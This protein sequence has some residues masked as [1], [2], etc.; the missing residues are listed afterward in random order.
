V[1]LPDFHIEIAKQGWLTQ[2]GPDA[3]D[4]EAALRDL[5]SHGDIRLVIGGQTIATGSGGEFGISEAALGLLRT[6]TSARTRSPV[7]RPE[8]SGLSEEEAQKFQRLIPHGCGLFLMMNCNIGID[9][10]VE[11][12][13]GRVRISEVYRCDNNDAADVFDHPDAVVELPLAEYRDA[14]VDFARKAKELFEGV[15][16]SFDEDCERDWYLAFWEE[17]DRLLADAAAA[18]Y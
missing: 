4:P 1:G 2:N 14:I 11:H 12:L 16:K 6:I 5:C 15:T 17:Y 18:A 3:N 7:Q 8:Y 9:W 10:T 13:D